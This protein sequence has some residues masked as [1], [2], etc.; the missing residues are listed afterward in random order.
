MFN[1]YIRKIL[2]IRERYLDLVLCGET[3]SMSIPYVSEAELFAVMRTSGGR[4]LLFVGNSN[5]YEH[6]TGAL[7]FSMNNISLYD[8][9]SETS[10]P[11]KE[12]KLEVTLAAG[13]CMLIELPPEI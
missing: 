7:E 8:L 10:W 12:H 5:L 2:D 3:G 11:I 9:I 13:Q 6:R 4:S 1:R